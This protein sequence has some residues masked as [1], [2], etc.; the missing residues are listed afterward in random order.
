MIGAKIAFDDLSTS[1]D[2]RLVTPP[3]DLDADLFPHP[4]AA[5]ARVH[6]ISWG[7]N[8]NDYDVYGLEVC[9]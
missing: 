3:S 5:G 8:H 2:G 1:A 9:L 4:Y 6:T 7:T